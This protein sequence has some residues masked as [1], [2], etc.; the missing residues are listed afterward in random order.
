MNLFT[1]Y[2]SHVLG[3]IQTLEKAGL[4][5]EGLPTDAIEVSPPREAAHGDMATNVAMVLAAKAGKKPRDIAELVVKELKTVP[6]VANVEIAGP[7]FIN[8]T[9]KPEVWQGVIPEIL[10]EGIAYGNSQ[11][12][13]NIRVNVE[14]VSANPTGPMHVGHGRGAVVGDATAMLLIKAGY[15]VT[16]E[17]YIN[18]AG[19]QVQVLCDSVMLRYREALGEFIGEIPA[20]LYP[21]E[22]MKAVG[23][24]LAKVHG[25]KLLSAPKEVWY[26]IV[27]EYAVES[28]MAMI[29][30]DLA[31]MGIHHDVFASEYE[32]TKAGRVEEAIDVLKEKGLVYVGV[33]EPPKGKPAPEDWE[34]R[35]QTLFKSTQFG[36]DVD[37]AL[38]KSDGSWTY[39]APDIAYHFDKYKR[40]HDVLIDIFGADHGGYAK[41]IKAV[42]QALSDGKCQVDV[43]L[44]QLVKLMRAGEP[45]KMSK[46]AGTFV[47]LRE[48]V[49]EVGKDVFRFIMLTRKNDASLDFDFAK[50]TEQS[51]DNPVFYVQYAHARCKSVL[52]MAQEEQPEAVK[53]SLTPTAAQLSVMSTPA[54]LELIKLL[55]TW[56]RL[57]EQAALA[58][59]PHRIAFYLQELAAGFH[60]FWNK[61]NEDVSLRFIL[62]DDLQKTIARLALVRSVATVIAS[63]LWVLGVEPAEE[64]R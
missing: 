31:L 22:Y 19:A 64:M 18:D 14:Y 13:K 23:E 1:L 38:Q 29:K 10:S 52:R 55:A 15:S 26:P 24:G 28:L 35:P 48:V 12:G 42:V 3:I 63:G 51:K 20:G 17:Y 54:E 9:L 44:C 53:S 47:T 30:D 33:L 6:T 27:R 2:R 60:G 36:D 25:N 50:V 4:H 57:V 59:E 41:R 43:K 61:G 56:P 58:Y 49:E 5:P 46:R 7:G 11:V 34:P 39:F 16:K 37:R 62:K 8:I 40:G 21:G 32:I 45:V